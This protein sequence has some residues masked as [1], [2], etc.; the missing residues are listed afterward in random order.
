MWFRTKKDPLLKQV[1]L[2]IKTIH[3]NII[4][5]NNLAIQILLS[6]GKL[7]PYDIKLCSGS[8][9]YLY[10]LTKE[11]RDEFLEVPTE[12]GAKYGRVIGVSDKKMDINSSY[13]YRIVNNDCMSYAVDEF[14]DLR[15]KILKEL[16]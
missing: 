2:S 11:I 4:F 14:Y 15:D 7:V 1:I 16:K 6:E 8:K 3:D 12:N 9:S 13:C 5:A 10:F